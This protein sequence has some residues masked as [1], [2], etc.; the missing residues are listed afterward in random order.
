MQFQHYNLT[1]DNIILPIN[2]AFDNRRISFSDI[3][4][5]IIQSFT[6]PVIY[7]FDYLE[8]VYIV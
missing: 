4:E 2:D 6:L 1:L 8:K 5:T 3:Q 7:N